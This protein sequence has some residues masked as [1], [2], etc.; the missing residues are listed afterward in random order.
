MIR[1][2]LTI[3]FDLVK[4]SN[5]I[6]GAFTFG[7]LISSDFNFIFFCKPSNKMTNLFGVENDELSLNEIQWKKSMR[8]SD[9]N[10]SWGRPLK[11]ILAI[12]DKKKINF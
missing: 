4:P 2:F 5:A 12:F 3:L 1:S 6:S 9:F 7:P 8:W 11:S 10:L